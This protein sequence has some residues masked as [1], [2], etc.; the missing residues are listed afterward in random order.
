MLLPDTAPETDLVEV[1]RITARPDSGAVVGD[2]LEIRVEEQAR[3]VLDLVSELPGGELHRCFAPAYGVRAHSSTDLLFE[4]AFCFR[5][6]GALVL[7]PGVPSG[8]RGLQGFDPDSGPGRELL[9]LFRACAAT[10]G[11]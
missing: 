3:Q 6:H 11:E 9:D 8:L 4:I 7:G 10:P 1:V 5:C 2:V